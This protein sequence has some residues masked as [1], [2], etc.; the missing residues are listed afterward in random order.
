MKIVICDDSKS[1]ALAAKEVIKQTL[2]GLHIKA[3]FDYYSNATD[4]ERKLIIKKEPLDILIL[5]I[6]MPEISGI[7][8]A[9]RL[10]A[11]NLKLIII[12]L[13]NHEEYVFKAI[14]FQPFRYIRKIK[15]KAEM[16]LAI[17]AAARSIELQRDKQIVLNT[18][19]GEIRVMISE[20]IYFETE[21]RKIAIHLQNGG[22]LLVNKTISQIQEEISNEKFIMIHRSCIVNANYISNMKDSII[23]LK[24]G[25]QL[26]AS[27]RKFKDIKQQVLILWGESI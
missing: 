15:L 3:E 22:K 21:R 4:I 9:E 19:D 23:Y 13:S 5:D 27:R 25:E 7:E 10:R 17:K 14:E 16:P 2:H 6:D 26:L 12:F 20:I 18:D 1:D 8:L 11:N 24:N